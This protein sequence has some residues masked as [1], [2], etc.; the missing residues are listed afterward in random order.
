MTFVTRIYHHTQEFPDEEKY[1]LVSQLRRAAVSVP[2]NIAEG[3]GRRS[4]NEFNRFLNIAMA[5]LFEVQ[6]QVEIALNLDYLDKELFDELFEQS[7]EIERMMSS[8]I[9]SLGVK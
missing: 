2:S 7:R 6:T 5:S 8:F 1:G 4:D 9:R 3:F